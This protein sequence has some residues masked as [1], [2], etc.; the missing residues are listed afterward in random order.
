M[1]NFHKNVINR[2]YENSSHMKSTKFK[3]LY[4]RSINC[5]KYSNK[6]VS[7]SGVWKCSCQFQCWCFNYK[8]LQTHNVQNK[9][10]VHQCSHYYLSIFTSNILS[11][12][13]C[14][15]TV[16]YDAL[17]GINTTLTRLREG[18]KTPSI[19]NFIMLFVP[20]MSKSWSNNM[21]IFIQSNYITICFGGG[22]PSSGRQ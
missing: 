16:L 4:L 8:I 20:C 18:I 12:F 10:T 1:E 9:D 15:G 22:H 21:H 6:I 3:T 19:T 7:G 17:H 5:L 14:Q 2:V 13:F 11:P